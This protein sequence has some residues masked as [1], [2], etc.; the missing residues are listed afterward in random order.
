MTESEAD[1]RN[2]DALLGGMLL[3]ALVDV[4][5]QFVDVELGRINDEV[6]EATDCAEVTALFFQRRLHWRVGTER[7]RAACFTEPTQ[8]HGVGGLKKD[9]LGG[10]HAPH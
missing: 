10:N 3:E 4:S 7:M 9:D 2:Q 6:G 5:T 1:A 8:Q